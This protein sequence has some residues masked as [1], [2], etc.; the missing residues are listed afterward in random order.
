MPRDE[1]AGRVQS[2]CGLASAKPI[3]HASQGCKGFSWRCIPLKRLY[4]AGTMIYTQ[5]QFGWIPGGFQK[6]HKILKFLFNL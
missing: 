2:R 1:S 3:Y 5:S 6:F 4:K